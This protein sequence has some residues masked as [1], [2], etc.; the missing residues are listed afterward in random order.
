MKDG[1]RGRELTGE[2]WKSE[3]SRLMVDPTSSFLK[4]IAAG[5]AEAR[6]I[7]EPRPL[8]SPMASM[9]LVTPFISSLKFT[10]GQGRRSEMRA[11]AE[12]SLTS[13]RQEI[14]L[15]GLSFPMRCSEDGVLNHEVF[16]DVEPMTTIVVNPRNGL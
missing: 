15:W 5:E 1:V 12:G 9:N 14:D 3:G 4:S 7:P 10:E 2:Y 6:W 13:I 16:C 11:C 8:V